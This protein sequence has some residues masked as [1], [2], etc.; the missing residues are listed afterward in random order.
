MQIPPERLIGIEE[1]LVILPLM[2]I[3]T[4]GVSSQK[5]LFFKLIFLFKLFLRLFSNHHC[6]PVCTTLLI[7]EI[8]NM[9]Q[10]GGLS[11]SE[12]RRPSLPGQGAKG[13]GLSHLEA[14]RKPGDKT[15]NMSVSIL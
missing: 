15:E 2:S 10:G 1:S 3:I 11:P 14:M 8:G 7:L 5:S 13:I 12:K 6:Y 4:N 9:Q